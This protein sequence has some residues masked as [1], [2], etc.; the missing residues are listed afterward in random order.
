[1]TLLVVCIGLAYLLAASRLFANRHLV[2]LASYSAGITLYAVM[3][4]AYFHRASLEGMQPDAGHLVFVFGLCAAPT[5]LLAHMAAPFSVRQRA[6]LFRVRRTALPAARQFILVWLAGTTVYHFLVINPVWAA[7]RPALAAEEL[8][9]GLYLCALLL[10]LIVDSL[11]HPGAVGLPKS[12]AQA[13]AASAHNAAR[14]EARA[15]EHEDARVLRNQ[16]E[17]LKADAEAAERR[18]AAA[19]LQERAARLQAERFAQ[20]FARARKA[21]DMKT[22]SPDR[23]L[24]LEDAFRVLRLAPSCTQDQAKTAY[25]NMMLRYH[26]D[27]VSVMGSAIRETAEKESKKINEAYRLVSQAFQKRQAVKA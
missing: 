8:P 4:Y 23:P 16:L 3:A 21:M 14:S 6:D 1:M 11:M 9:L 2:P 19:V 26:P 27:K 13:A 15:T 17:R 10:L 24:T 7:E 18:W 25:R 12:Q 5:V 22:N 20:D